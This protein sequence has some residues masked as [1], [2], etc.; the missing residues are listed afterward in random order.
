[1]KASLFYL[2]LTVEKQLNL[3]FFLCLYIGKNIIS[4]I[5]QYMGLPQHMI[6]GGLMALIG[7]FP[8]MVS[9]ELE[10]I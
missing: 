3:L 5:K 1:M 8:H 4:H 7:E 2:S 9:I 10:I 6:I